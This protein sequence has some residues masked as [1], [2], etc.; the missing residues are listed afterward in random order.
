VILASCVGHVNGQCGK[1]ERRFHTIVGTYFHLI[2]P[3]VP[4]R[5]TRKDCRERGR[6]QSE[7]WRSCCYRPQDTCENRCIIPDTH[8]HAPWRL[9]TAINTCQTPSC[10]RPPS[11]AM[12]WKPHPC[13]LYR[14][15]WEMTWIEM[16]VHSKT[17]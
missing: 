8:L 1:S 4:L 14:M 10:A 2:H 5:R 11:L 12:R 13:Y 7:R 16:K 15:S 17:H 3:T 9:S 6:P